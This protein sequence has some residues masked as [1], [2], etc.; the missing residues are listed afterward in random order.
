MSI[1][2]SVYRVQLHPPMRDKGARGN[3]HPSE[4]CVTRPGWLATVYIKPATDQGTPTC[5]AW[6][7]ILSRHLPWKKRYPFEKRVF[8]RL[9]S[10]DFSAIAQSPPACWH[11]GTK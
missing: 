5:R 3:T 4:H 11:L 10:T 1:L 9:F 8:F 2:Y 7:N 6:H